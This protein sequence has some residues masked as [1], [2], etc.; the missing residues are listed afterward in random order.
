MFIVFTYK[1]LF[2]K[3]KTKNKIHFKQYFSKANRAKANPV[4]NSK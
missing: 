1:L 4:T 2:I 3:K